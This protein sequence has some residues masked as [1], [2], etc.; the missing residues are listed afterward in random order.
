VSGDRAWLFYFTHPG[1][2]G[3]DAKKDG[4]EQRRSV[5]QVTELK[6]E[7]G[8]LRVDRDVPTHIRLQ[9]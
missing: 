4:P 8:W 3:P 1:R 9:E 5:I 7:G 2:R 6:E